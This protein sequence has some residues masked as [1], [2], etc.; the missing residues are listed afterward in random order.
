M[1]K[2]SLTAMLAAVELKNHLK[3][4]LFS[5]EK[6]TVI[7]KVIKRYNL[8]EEQVYTA[9]S[10]LEIGGVKEVGDFIKAL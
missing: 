8:S 5:S 10:A 3:G 2:V 9:V 1:N 7:D 4:D 6:R